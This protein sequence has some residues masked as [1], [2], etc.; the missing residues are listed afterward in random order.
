MSRC[1]KELIQN[2]NLIIGCDIGCN[3]CYA[4]GLTN[5]YHITEDFSVPEYYPEKLRIMARKKP[6][7]LFLTGMSDF[8][9][10]DEKWR[11]EIFSHIEKNPHNQY[12]FLTKRPE[13]LN[14]ST[15]P[16][17]VWIGVTVTSSKEKDRIRQLRE[18]CRCRHYHVTFEPMFDDVG[19]LDLKGIDWI[20]I[21]T[22][23]GCR[24]NKAVTDPAWAYSIVRQAEKYHVPVF[25]KEDLIS[26]MGDENMIQ[27]LPREFDRILKDQEKW[28]K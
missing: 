22:E 23:T 16:E 8:A 12:I 20:V 5:R 21:G 6:R 14:F 19:E 27:Q 11:D 10:W 28:K 2:L 24:K 3:Y 26:I 9:G 7:N 25:M 13:R 17:N 4:R 1:I 15:D 18:N